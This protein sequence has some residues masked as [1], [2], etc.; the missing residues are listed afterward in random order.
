MMIMKI[1]QVKLIKH[2]DQMLFCSNFQLLAKTTLTFLCGT[3]YL[4]FTLAYTH[5]RAHARTHVHMNTHTHTPRTR[6]RTRKHTPHTRSDL[7]LWY[8]LFGIHLYSYLL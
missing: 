3:F 8:I 2:V 1:I 5:T 4:V 7:S 6:T